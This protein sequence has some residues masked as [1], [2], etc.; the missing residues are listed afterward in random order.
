MALHVLIELIFGPPSLLN[1][2]GGG[3]VTVNLDGQESPM[4]GGHLL[5]SIS[6]PI[7]FLTYKE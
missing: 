6:S 5:R 3:K 4:L 1:V 2:L 7:A